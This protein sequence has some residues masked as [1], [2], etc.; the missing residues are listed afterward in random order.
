MKRTGEAV[1]G[2]PETFAVLAYPP[3]TEYVSV[4]MFAIELAGIIPKYITDIPE[5]HK[6]SM[7]IN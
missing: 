1:D 7:R 2:E 6:F 5:N 4:V 3:S